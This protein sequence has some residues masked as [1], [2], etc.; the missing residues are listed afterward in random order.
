VAGAWGLLC[1]GAGEGAAAVAVGAVAGCQILHAA[2]E[3]VAFGVV[4]GAFGFG[5]VAPVAAAAD[6]AGGVDGTA[7]V[8]REEG[9][10]AFARG[11]GEWAALA[12]ER[13]SGAGAFDGEELDGGHEGF[14]AGDA[15]AAALG[16][17]LA[18]VAGVALVD[19]AVECGELGEQDFLVVHA[20]GLTLTGPKASSK[21]RCGSNSVVECN[22]A[23]VDVAGSNPV[24]RSTL[25]ERF[26]AVERWC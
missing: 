12:R 26:V 5:A 4:D 14:A 23:K 22:L 19:F 10:G 1:E 13:A 16:R 2:D 20:D 21:H 6:R 15:E 18:L 25:L 8:F 7:G 11:E 9:A 24:S 17:S 3:G